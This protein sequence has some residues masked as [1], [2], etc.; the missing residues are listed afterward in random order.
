VTVVVFLLQHSYEADD[1]DETKIIGV[2]SSRELAEQAAERLRSQPGF[3]DRP[4]NFHVDA[5]PVD[6]DHWTE[7][8]ERIR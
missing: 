2:Y 8:Y 5:Y 6:Q 3:S 1:C 7:G 4:N